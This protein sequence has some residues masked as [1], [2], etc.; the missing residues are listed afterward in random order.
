[1][2]L[3]SKQPQFLTLLKRSAQSILA[4][5]RTDAGKQVFIGSGFII[6]AAFLLWPITGGDYP[7]G[8]D[9]PTFLHL[10]WVTDLAVSGELS[11]SL[12]DPFWYGGFFYLV[13]PPLSYG[14]VGLLSALTPASLV[15]SYLSVLILAYGAFGF[16]VSFLAREFGLKWW[17]AT[18]AGFFVLLAYPSLNS[19]F[20]WGWFTTV[21][22]LPFAL[23]SVAFLERSVQRQSWRWAVAAG[24][25]MALSALAH[26]MTALTISFGLVPWLLIHLAQGPGMRR[27]T[28]VR[29][30]LAATTTVILILP[31][32]IPFLVTTSD[33]D[34]RREIPGNW[35]A[36]LS[37]YVSHVLNPD[38][39][40]EF[41]FPSYLGVVLTTLALIGLFLS[42]I[43]RNR[44]AG[45]ALTSILLLWFSLGT[46]GNPLIDHY[47]F[48]ALD[49]ARLHLFLVPFLA[50]LAASTVERFASAIALARQS[51]QTP[52]G[53]GIAVVV[54]TVVVLSY[55]AY[56]ALEARSLAESYVVESSVAEAL[57]W[58]TEE[59]G[60]E[61]TEGSSIF[62]VGFWNWHAFLIPTLAERKI[63][64]GW[65]D[66]GA[67]NVKLI[68]ELRNMA[69]A[70]GEPVDAQRVH[71][72]LVQLKGK[73]VVL[74]G[75]YWVGERANEYLETMRQR[76]DLF[77]FRQSWGDIRIFEVL[78]TSGEKSM[79]QTSE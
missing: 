29:M 50:I 9:T 52:V 49:I 13:Y 24:V 33:T 8:V 64:D 67:D 57:N 73:F 22:S 1:M 17:P 40:G 15:H 66:E 35:Q 4:F 12:E 5:A 27:D 58:L 70:G 31:W 10:A 51:L 30:L 7:P 54:T 28:V 34:F 38:L 75:S 69:W 55:P 46:E 74:H 36:S 42:L 72:I 23:L 26:H 48:S 61:D 79:A 6:L 20:L 14:I 63:V 32:A 59:S 25:L 71:E 3:A 16:S 76:P 43:E 77:V 56:T 47:P 44:L 2:N 78:E 65:H 62:A 53:W 45:I 39:V 19:V 68:R 37:T 60:T 11:N 21:V 18:L 41:V